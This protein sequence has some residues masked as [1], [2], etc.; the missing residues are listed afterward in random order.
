VPEALHRMVEIYTTLGL[1]E[2]AKRTA[3]VM[4]HNFPGSEWYEDTFSLVKTGK[5]A[6]AKQESSGWFGLW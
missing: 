3:A 1:D 2:E 5:N 6:S 4:G